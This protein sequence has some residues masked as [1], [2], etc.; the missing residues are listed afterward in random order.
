MYRVFLIPSEESPRTELWLDAYEVH[1]SEAGTCWDFVDQQNR[2]V[3]RLDKASVKS[4]IVAPDRR[5][6]RPLEHSVVQ[7]PRWGARE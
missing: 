6:P 7:D 4:F 1:E 2:L 5:K 3:R